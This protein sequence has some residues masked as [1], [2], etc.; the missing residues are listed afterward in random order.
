M[1]L[2][3]CNWCGRLYL[4]KSRNTKYCSDYCR[5]EAKLE[6]NRNSINKRNRSER[7]FN[8]RC[9]NLTELGSKGTDSNYH[10]KDNFKD[11]AVSVSAQRRRLRI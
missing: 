2:G 11:E 5:N 9:K 4:K 1:F 3:K 6:S 7:Y 10:M 8:T